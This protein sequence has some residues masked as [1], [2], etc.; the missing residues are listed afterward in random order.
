M[1]R[2]IAPLVLFL[3]GTVLVVAGMVRPNVAMGSVPLSLAQWGVCLAMASL[4]LWVT[5]LRKRLTGRRRTGWWYPRD[6]IPHPGARTSSPQTPPGRPA[7][8]R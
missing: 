5:A 4:V 2:A 7:S 1:L 6:R 3:L 8:L